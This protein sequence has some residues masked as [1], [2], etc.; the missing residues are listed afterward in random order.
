MEDKKNKT[1]V[2]HL[3]EDGLP[4]ADVS[5]YT[6]TADHLSSYDRAADDLYKFKV[7]ALLD[8]QDRHSYILFALM[9]GTGND[10]AKDPLHATNVARFDAQLTKLQKS[11]YN[12][13][14]VYEAGPGTQKN[15][16]AEKIDGAT[17]YT[18][19]KIAERTYKRIV[20]QAQEIYRLDPDAKLTIHAEG[21]SRGASQVPLLTRMIHDRGIPNLDRPEY[22]K[23]DFGNITKTYPHFHQSPGHTPLSVGLYDP[24][25]TGAMEKLDRRL[26]PS[27]VSG[28]QINAADEK[29]GKFPVDR[30]IPQG[31]SEDGRFLSVSVAGAH[32]DIGGSYL[33]NGLGTRSHNLMTDYHNALFSEPLLRR[34]PETY[35]PRLN[36]IHRSEEGSIFKYLPKT[37]RD[38]P[39]GEVTKLMPDAKAPATND[40]LEA[41]VRSRP[42]PM[43][44]IVADVAQRA[45]PVVRSIPLQMT[46]PPAEEAME[47]WFKKVGQVEVQAYQPPTQLTP[48]AKVMAAAGVAGIAASVV[49]AKASADRAS[50]LLSQDNPLAAQSELT[51]YAARGTGGWIGGATAG[52]V[53]TAAATGPGVVGFIVVGGTAV[54]GAHVGE[55]VATVLDSYQ[56][57]KQTD[58]DGVAWESNGRQWVR[59]DLGDLSDDGRNNPVKQVFSA[60]PEKANEL[61]YRASNSATELAIGKLESPRNP[62]AQAAAEADPPSLRRA[63]WERNPQSGE[64]DRKVVV[65][66]E[67][68]GVPM[69]RVDSAS[70]ERTAELNRAAEQTILNN[71]ANGPAP[72]AARYAMVHRSEGWERFGAVPGSIN[73]AL[74]D[75]SLV[76]SDGKL[77]QRTAD[78]QWQRNG[79]SV[80]A[81]GNLRQE[82]DGTR[83]ALQPQLAQHEQQL[84][85]IPTRQPST[86][87]DIKRADL[88]ATYKVHNVNPNPEQL[89]A[90]MEA[91]RR[92][93]HEQGVAPLATSLHLGRNAAGNFDIDSP[94]EHIGRDADG[95]NRVHA[96]TSPL[97]VQLAMLDLRS[98]PPTSPE[99]PE[100]RIANLSPKQQEALEQ[101]VRE[102]NRVGLTRDEVQGTAREAVA[103]AGRADVEPEIV[104]GAVAAER[105]VQPTKVEVPRAV[106]QAP[107]EPPKPVEADLAS[108]KPLEPH[109]KPERRDDE[110]VPDRSS[111]APLASA[112]SAPVTPA[113]VSPEAK[114]APTVSNGEFAAPPQQPERQAS[115]LPDQ[116]PQPEVIAAQSASPV[117]RPP[118]PETAPS[119]PVEAPAAAAPRVAPQAVAETAFAP[120]V[121]SSAAEATPAPATAKADVAGPGA[122]TPTA[123]AVAVASAPAPDDS[124]LQHGDRGQEVELLQY[125]LQRVGYRGP[126]DAPV[127]ERGHFDAATE[128]A[129]RHLQRDHG[130]AET[131]RV[132]PD[133]LQALAVAQQA[134]IEAQKAVPQADG[135]EVAKVQGQPAQATDGQKPQTVVANEPP[136][137]API[138]PT[139]EVRAAPAPALA[140]Y[141]TPENDPIVAAPK[142][143]VSDMLADVGARESAQ[144]SYSQAEPRKPVD[145]RAVHGQR[146]G[147]PAQDRR[148]TERELARLS[149]ADQAMFAKIRGAAPASVPDEVVAKAMLEA[150]RNGIPD[151]ERVGQVGIADGKLWVGSVTPGFHAAVSANGPAPNM[152]DTLKETQMVNQQRDQQLAMEATQR[153]QDEQRAKPIMH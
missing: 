70:P 79:E 96:V 18:S 144:P 113:A 31:A 95:A 140:G 41:M 52:V 7:P 67:Q 63:D 85:A 92:T 60:D 115:G 1:K 143:Q 56:T 20:D 68:R 46:A 42:E 86:L 66:F 90:A 117:A 134:K 61:S 118:Q 29:R 150:K 105:P 9:D 77:Y 14:V 120:P 73:A 138:M 83:A 125:R 130:L 22:V 47:A 103:A 54:A 108:S 48:G 153:Q 16:I 88:M 89:E 98:P 8:T 53:A 99:A 142:T 50:T 45:A 57:F 3:A 81:A 34:L 58:R 101:V 141:A 21:F 87:E 6:A 146:A 135:A 128:H 97:E 84:A 40:P 15:V 39:A 132:D 94:I 93:Q 37:Q 49:D 33:R 137:T 104:I 107:A 91:V 36:A 78:G 123:P 64:W 80:V 116:Q 17:G 149:P 114:P 38:L 24:V 109:S 127:P 75:D 136:Q 28:F 82:L 55:H 145:S 11:G 148:E 131:G 27:V 62:Y 124:T 126:D 43:S 69:V 102:A 119:A 12:V 112:T 10:A 23:D 19:E 4:K 59:Q 121:A 30:I 26:P 74:Q 129:V 71:I 106:D 100:L 110:A 13:A 139:A 2:V 5:H 44:P 152:Q 72:M 76:A 122:P 111:G 151:V 133:T 35:D 51:H 32:S 65:G 25:P 147:E